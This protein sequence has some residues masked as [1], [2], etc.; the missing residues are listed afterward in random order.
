MPLMNAQEDVKNAI[1]MLKAKNGGIST[2]S[3]VVPGAA[4]EANANAQNDVPSAVPVAQPTQDLTGG[5]NSPS[6]AMTPAMA[7][8]MPPSQAL[9]A[10]PSLDT[11][12]QPGGAGWKMFEEKLKADKQK[13]SLLDQIK[14]AKGLFGYKGF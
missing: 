11:L 3:N 6:P 1:A 8:A 4:M 5:S 9:S 2:S 14:T 7:P 13:P 12:A 10:P